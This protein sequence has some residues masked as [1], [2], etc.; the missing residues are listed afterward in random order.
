MKKPLLRLSIR[1]F[2]NSKTSIF[3]LV[4]FVLSS[5]FGIKSNAQPNV[6]SVSAI[7]GTDADHV[8]DIIIDGSGNTY[9][10][11]AF[12]V[13]NIDFDPGPGT[14]N[15]TSAGST[16]CYLLKLDASGN[17]VWAI[18]WGGT[19][20]DATQEIDFDPSG[21]IVI[22]GYATGAVDFDPGPGT[23]NLSSGGQHG[24][25][26]K[27]DP[28]GNFLWARNFTGSTNNVLRM[29]V[30]GS[31]NIY[32]SGLTAGTVDFD[33]G[34]GTF[35]LVSAGGNDVFAAKLDGSGNLLWARRAGGTG[36]DLAYPIVTDASGNVYV[37]GLFSGTAD[38]D[39]SAGT[40]N[41]VSVG[42]NDMF[43]WKLDASGNFIWAVSAGGTSADV[44]Y[45][46]TLDA[47]DNILLTG[48]FSNT[49]DFDPSAGT[50]NLVAATSDPFVWKLDPSGN[51]VWAG[52]F[53]G[54][55]SADQGTEVITDALGNVYI[56]G[57]F[58]PAATDFNP[59][60]G[61]AN[62]T[63]AGGTDIFLV[64]LD[65]SGNYQW[66]W[67]DGGVSNEWLNDFMI[68]PSGNFYIGGAYFSTTSLGGNSFTAP[69]A[70]SDA[71]YMKLT[72]PITLP[73][74]LIGF[75]AWLENEKAQL[76]WITDN[77]EN[78]SHFEI[79]RSTDGADFAA[80]GRIMA[81]NV[82]FRNEYLYTDQTFSGNRGVL[83]YKDGRYRRQ[84]FPQ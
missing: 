52:A 7:S 76:K 36:S 80:I 66:S 17:F 37:A 70:N 31:G 11:G 58:G 22:G 44:I 74:H 5:L 3:Y 15:L 9:Y 71:F 18:R 28:S 75:N 26:M 34:A 21:N 73:L 47:S 40:F 33:P 49:A 56:G 83:P 79:E 48:S 64:K 59:G 55:G 8:Y 32:A 35:N 63:A 4:I 1:D 19:G 60:A 46:S 38:F 84:V 43:V 82:A 2:R 42:L 10:T 41:L 61:T 30:D 57:K 16:D 65:A 6:Q 14:Y 50:F 67:Q 24:F 78:V 62:R 77:E 72:P 51:L 23:F 20:I 25:V 54:G 29:H 39:P 69:N 81:K 45:G 12:G 68:D 53:T 13:A 27:V